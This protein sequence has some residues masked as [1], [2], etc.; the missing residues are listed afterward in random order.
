[1]QMVHGI[2]LSQDKLIVDLCQAIG[3]D[4]H[5]RMTVKAS[6]AELL[7]GLQ[8]EDYQFALFDCVP[9]GMDCLKW[10]YVIRRLR[11]KIPLLVLSDQIDT[12]TAARMHEAGIFYLFTRPLQ[13]EILKDILGAAL[14]YRHKIQVESKF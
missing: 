12:E 2:V 3:K 10:V 6:L 1:M 11:P 8:E 4:I 13:P 14:S 5:V 9:I 7:L